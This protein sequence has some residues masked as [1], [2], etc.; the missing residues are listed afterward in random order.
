M[1]SFAFP[2]LIKMTKLIFRQM[3]HNNNMFEYSAMQ[4]VQSSNWDCRQSTAPINMKPT[5]VTAPQLEV[6]REVPTTNHVSIPE[7]PNW[8]NIANYDNIS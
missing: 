2:D 8:K 7:A 6:F 5:P 4:S 3:A 1:E